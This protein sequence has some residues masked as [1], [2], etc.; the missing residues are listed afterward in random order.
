MKRILFIIGCVLAGC[1][2]EGFDRRARSA[3]LGDFPWINQEQIEARGDITEWLSVFRNARAYELTITAHGVPVYCVESRSTPRVVHAFYDT[4]AISMKHRAPPTNEEAEAALRKNIDAF[5]STIG[6]DFIVTEF[7]KYIY[8]SVISHLLFSERLGR[9][10]TDDILKGDVLEP[11]VRNRDGKYNF[12]LF[13][14]NEAGHVTY[15]DVDVT[16][17]GKVEGWRVAK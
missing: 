13:R 11:K 10:P 4:R 1:S 3:I 17:G 12:R 7:N 9:M 15:W 5:N 14:S 6:S 16:D 2:S 8:A